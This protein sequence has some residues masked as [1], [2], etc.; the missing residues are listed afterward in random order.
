M[1]YLDMFLIFFK[2]GL[3]T[4]GG[5]YASLPLIQQEII[6]IKGWMSTS[7]F[8]DVLTISEMT[9]GSIAIN[10]ATFVGR[11]LLGIPGAIIATIGVVLPSIIVV[12]LLAVVYYKFRN[13]SI[14]QG[15]LEGLRPA[16]V[17]LIGGAASTILLTT[18]FGTATFPVSFEQFNVISFGLLLLSLGLLYK[19]RLGPIYVIIL[20][21]ILGLFVFSIF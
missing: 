13:F 10:A 17:A 16:I 4:F 18:L 14:V 9:P 3:L 6:E 1:I 7:Q 11:N 15:I 8:V 19:T 12:L 21:G 2:I 20:S 5:G